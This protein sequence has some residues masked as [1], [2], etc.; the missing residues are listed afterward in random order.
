MYVAWSIS[1]M[2]ITDHS[3][4]KRRKVVDTRAGR[5]AGATS[6]P[7]FSLSPLLNPVGNDDMIEDDSAFDDIMETLLPE[8]LHAR[9]TI[10]SGESE[11]VENVSIATLQRDTSVHCI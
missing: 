9:S 6:Q 10:Q 7:G 5:S 3:Q 2:H 4:R 11:T 8:F 1:F